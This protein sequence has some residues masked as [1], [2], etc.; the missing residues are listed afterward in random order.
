ML[1]NKDVEDGQHL[2]SSDT[3]LHV[4]DNFLHDCQAHLNC[5]LAFH[6]QYKTVWQMLRLFHPLP[7][8]YM[9]LFFVFWHNFILVS[10][11]A[12]GYQL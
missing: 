11:T 3:Q 2:S 10:D 7:D 8:T 5:L 6:K 1:K 4:T 12:L 9:I